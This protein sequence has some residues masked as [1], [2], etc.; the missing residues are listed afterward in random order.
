MGDGVEIRFMVAHDKVTMYIGKNKCLF[1][2]LWDKL[3]N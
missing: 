3:F 2:Y 1:I